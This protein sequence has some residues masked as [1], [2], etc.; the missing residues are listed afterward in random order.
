MKGQAA[1]PCVMVR[2]NLLSRRESIWDGQPESLETERLDPRDQDSLSRG[3][4]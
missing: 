4:S 3:D 2:I 1:P